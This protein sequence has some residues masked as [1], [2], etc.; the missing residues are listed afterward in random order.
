VR[1][2]GGW[3]V[4]RVLEKKA[5]D[6][7]AFDKEKASLMATLRQQRKDELFRAFL[8]EAR[9]RVTVQRNAEAFKRAMAS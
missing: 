7:A 6:P 3:A 2:A 8:A 4:S 1:V 5:L 9:K